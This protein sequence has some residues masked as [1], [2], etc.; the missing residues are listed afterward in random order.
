MPIFA[1]ASAWD[2]FESS[3]YLSLPGRELFYVRQF[4]RFIDDA[5]S[6]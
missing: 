6:I 3:S 4:P 2:F 5:A 1:V